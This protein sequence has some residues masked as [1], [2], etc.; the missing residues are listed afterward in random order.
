VALSPFAYHAPYVSLL[1]M[2][3]AASVLAMVQAHLLP[4]DKSTPRVVVRVTPSRRKGARRQ[5]PAGPRK[6]GRWQHRFAALA[7]GHGSRAE[8]SQPGGDRTGL[9]RALVSSPTSTK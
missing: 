8:E 6:R 3:A 2:L 4:T 1:S 7:S 5:V 9:Q